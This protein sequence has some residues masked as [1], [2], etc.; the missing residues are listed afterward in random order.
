VFDS[1]WNKHNY[2]KFSNTLCHRFLT[3][4]TE[5]RR[6]FTLATTPSNQQN[7]L[8]TMVQVLYILEVF[9]L[10]HYGPPSTEIPTTTIVRCHKDSWIYLT[11]TIYY[12]WLL[13]PMATMSVPCSPIIR[14]QAQTLVISSF[15][16]WQRTNSVKSV[17]QQQI[18]Y[19]TVIRCILPVITSQ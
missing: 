1:I 8:L 6:F 9:I 7:M 16:K 18:F 19:I 4:L 13:R 14:V 2:L 17:S 5:W 11:S 10:A 3:H 12:W 15:S